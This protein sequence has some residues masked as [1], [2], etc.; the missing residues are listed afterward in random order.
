LMTIPASSVFSDRHAAV[1]Y[2]NGRLCQSLIRV[3]N[4]DVYVTPGYGRASVIFL[5]YNDM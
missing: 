1:Q 2:A 5:E 3:C 4:V